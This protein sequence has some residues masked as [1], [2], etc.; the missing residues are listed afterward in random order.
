MTENALILSRVGSGTLSVR[1]PGVL[2]RD[3]EPPLK[4]ASEDFA[5]HLQT[6]KAVATRIDTNFRLECMAIAS[7]DNTDASLNGC[8]RILYLDPRKAQDK[9]LT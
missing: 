6:K 4:L 9:S 5:G 8:C 3:A 1:V 7:G 2:A